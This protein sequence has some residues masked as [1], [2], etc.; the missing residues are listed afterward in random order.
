VW[1]KRL[2]VRIIGTAEFYCRTKRVGL[3]QSVK[4]LLGEFK[5]AGF[6][7]SDDLMVE[8]LRLAGEE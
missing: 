4:S 8:A 1:A 7:L 6:R 2:G 3:V 5:R